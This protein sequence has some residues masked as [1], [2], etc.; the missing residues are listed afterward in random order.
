LHIEVKMM[1]EMYKQKTYPLNIPWEHNE[2]SLNVLGVFESSGH[3]NWDQVSPR[4]CLHI[5]TSGTGIFNA[6][7]K[8][9]QVSENQ[10]FTFFPGQYI[11]YH[12]FPETPWH[13]TY[14][15]I[16][17]T[18]IS[19]VLSAIGVDKNNPVIDISK[20][21]KFKSV[22]STITEK[23]SSH[24]YDQFFSVKAAWELLSALIVAPAAQTVA[25]NKQLFDEAKILMENQ[26]DN[27]LTVDLLA[28]RLGVNRST[29]FRA[30]K[31]QNGTSPK[32]YIDNCRFEKAK[33]LLTRSKIPIKQV[34]NACGFTEHHYFSN[35]FRKRFGATPSEFRRK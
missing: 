29:L 17:G 23:V 20:N 22:L 31:N 8:A 9:Y 32:E 24:S 15:Y 28:D 2:L 1:Q 12:D 19:E 30:F 16:D 7:G 26:L 11:A 34:A 33:E 6:D 5:I 10:I 21:L 18:R 3:F 25:G 4:H 13:Y 35:A 27:N 14:C